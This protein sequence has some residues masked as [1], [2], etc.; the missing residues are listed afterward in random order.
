MKKLLLG[1]C[2]L[3]ISSVSYAGNCEN[4]CMSG[5]DAAVYNANE[6]VDTSAGLTTWQNSY[7]SCSSGCPIQ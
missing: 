1:V 3:A 2:F 6:S 4:A 5:A 7:N